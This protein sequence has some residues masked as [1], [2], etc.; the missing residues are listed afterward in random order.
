MAAPDAKVVYVGADHCVAL[1][2]N[3][4]LTVADSDPLPSFP[5]LLP[6]FLKRL[7]AQAAGPLGFYVV[8]P[9]HNPPPKEEARTTIKHAFHLFGGVVD[10]GAFAIEMTGFAAAGQRS[11]V[12][13]IMLA[14]R[15]PF[16]MKVFGTV[17]EASRWVV[18]KQG[19]QPQQTVAELNE[20][21]A[22][23]RAGYAAGTL[24]EAR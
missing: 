23:L 10:F 11:V 1:H 22:W 5:R 14:A 9:P 13:L 8:L 18:G 19:R 21:V 15:P 16:A 3:L 12:N 7:Q 17:D 6:G 24:R 2:R 4:L 20:T